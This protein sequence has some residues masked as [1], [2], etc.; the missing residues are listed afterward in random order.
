M[1]N[2]PGQVYEYGHI[3]AYHQTIQISAKIP[4]ILAID[5]HNQLKY[6]V[7]VTRSQPQA[8]CALR[9]AQNEIASQRT[10]AITNKE[11][12]TG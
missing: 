3:R 1:D 5:T 12:R 10:L 2:S 11:Y 8:R 4:A 9:T 6:T 7:F